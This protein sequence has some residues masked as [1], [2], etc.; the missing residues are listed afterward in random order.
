MASTRL[1]AQANGL[2]IEVVR[3]EGLVGVAPGSLDLIVTNP[4]FHV[5]AAKESTPTLDMI[6]DAGTALAPGG[7]VWCVFNSHL[8]YLPALAHAVGPTRIA[9]RDRHYTVTR[10]VRAQA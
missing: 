3:R 10:S 7:E 4:S 5:G 2:E 8:P 1:T 9:A 6:A